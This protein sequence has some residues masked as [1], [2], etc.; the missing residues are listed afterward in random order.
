ME[1][2]H[3]QLLDAYKDIASVLDKHGIRYYGVFGTAIGAVRHHGI[4]PWDDDLDIAIMAKDLDDVNKVLSEEL[5]P[6]KYYYH[7]PS[8]DS[9]PHVVIKTEDFDTTLKERKAAFIDI[10]VLMDYPDSSL[11]NALIYPFCG[12]EL[13]S[14]K[15]IDEHGKFIQSMFYGIMHISRKM[16]RFLS[17]EDTKRLNIRAVQVSKYSWFREDFN[18]TV[19][20][21]FDDTVMPIPSGYDRILT[22]FY[23]DYMT[24]PPEDQRSGATGYPYGLYKD[25][26]EDMSGDVKYPRLSCRDLPK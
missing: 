20:M 24:P 11:R 7:C 13:L 15:M 10:F 23:G 4:I 19:M 12:F 22:S 3:Q 6:S 26:L 1:N 8:A 17:K 9:H 14:H 18:E 25:Y 5:D 21:E 2:N 16:I